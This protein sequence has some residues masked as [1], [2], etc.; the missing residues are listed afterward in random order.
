MAVGTVI[1]YSTW[2]NLCWL[3]G[4]KQPLYVGTCA[5]MFLIDRR[6]FSVWVFAVCG[7]NIEVGEINLFIYMHAQIKWGKQNKFGYRSNVL[8]EPKRSKTPVKLLIL[9][10]R[11]VI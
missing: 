6:V 9:H 8:V 1:L 3:P 7:L 4:W 2:H 5:C 10:V 11:C